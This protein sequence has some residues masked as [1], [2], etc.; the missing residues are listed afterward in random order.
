[1]NKNIKVFKSHEVNAVLSCEFRTEKETNP[2]IEWKKKG[3]DVSYVYFDGEFTVPPH[4]PDC[5]VPETVMSGSAV[6][7]HCKDKLSVPPATY[8]WYKDNKPLSTAHLPD[9]NYSLDPKTGTL[10]FKSVSKSDAGQY[11]C[12]ASNAIGAP[13]SFFFFSSVELNLTLII[14]AGVG[15]GLFLLSCCLAI[16]LCCRRGYPHH[17]LVIVDKINILLICGLP[18]SWLNLFFS[19]I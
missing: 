14:A 7:L 10:K 8:S 2:R 6:E 1:M 19:G 12:E 9:I 18:M 5:Q 3:K 15:A 16:C 17:I 4:A 11:R 13:K